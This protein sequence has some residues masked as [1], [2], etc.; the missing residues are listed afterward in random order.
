MLNA[1]T[2]DIEDYFQVHAFSKVIK[3][4]D[5][6]NYECRI[7]RNTDRILEILDS[8]RSPILLKPQHS[9]T[10]ALNNSQFITHNLESKSQ[11]SPKG[12]FF[13]LGWIAERYPDLIRRIQREGHEIACHGYAHQLIYN[14]TK[15]AF[16]EDIRKSKAILEE[17]IGCEVI[18]Y[19]APS[20]SI[21][22]KSKWAFEILMEEGFKYDSSIF[23]I[24]HDF[25]GMPNAPRFPFIISLN[26]TSNVEFS[27]LNFDFK[28]T[29][30]SAPGPH[31]SAFSTTEQQHS[32]T[33]APINNSTLNTHNSNFLIEFPISTVRLFGQNVPISGGGYFRLFPYPIVKKGLERINKVEKR[34]FNFYLH[35]WEIDPDQPRINSVSFTFKFRHYSNLNKTENKFRKLLEDFNFLPV[36]E[37]MELNRSITKNS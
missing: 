29:Y 27:M 5:W 15:E 16:R 34:P 1:L 19:R 8:I 28:N 2:I 32:T 18:G 25:Y 26:E 22:N 17:I 33:A 7:E 20:Y 11:N 6:D 9:S 30:H 13:V 10:S 37:I 36:R 4:K 35:P 23:P 31:G 24:R 14:Q 12:S 21:T 3:F